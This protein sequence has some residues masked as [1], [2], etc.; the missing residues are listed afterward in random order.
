MSGAAAGGQ[1]HLIRAGIYFY[2]TPFRGLSQSAE[3]FLPFITSV[4]DIVQ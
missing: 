2:L 3:M 1:D 4:G